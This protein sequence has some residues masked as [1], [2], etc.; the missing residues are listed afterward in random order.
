MKIRSRLLNKFAA[1]CTVGLL[2]ML[3]RTTRIRIH[4]MEARTV[5]YEPLDEKFL[6]PVWHDSLAFPLFCGPIHDMSTLVSQHRDGSLLAFA[7]ES[8]G[9]AAVRG[10]S[11]RG[12]ARAVRQLIDSA[13]QVHITIT[14]DGPRGPKRELKS[15]IVFLASHMGRRIVPVGAAASRCWR[16]HGSWT[17]LVIPKPFSK[18]HFVTGKAITIPAKLSKDQLRDLTV[19]VE[20]QLHATQ[21]CAERLANGLIS[22][23]DELLAEPPAM[24]QAA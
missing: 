7:M 2:R 10:S 1:K 15:G 16:L 6:Y 13:K 23:I 18:V 21:S 17:D 9:V 22:S 24:K 11:S 19:I 14:P 3:F 8:L 12:G 5:A 20:Q 4:P